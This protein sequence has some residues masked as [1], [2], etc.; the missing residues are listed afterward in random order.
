MHANLPRKE[1]QEEEED[2]SLGKEKVL[3]RLSN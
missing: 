1:T 3:E 2:K